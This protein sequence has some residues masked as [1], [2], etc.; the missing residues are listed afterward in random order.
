MAQLFP[1]F[2]SKLIFGTVG[3][4]I[5]TYSKRKNQVDTMI[6]SSENLSGVAWDP[7]NKQLYFC[8][9]QA[10][11]RARH[12]GSNVRTVFTTSK[13]KL[14]LKTAV[15]SAGLEIKYLQIKIADDPILALSF[16][17]ISGSLYGGTHTGQVFAC[18]STAAETLSCVTIMRGKHRVHG[19][20]VDPNHG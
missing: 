9:A 12:D 14:S 17:W 19:I 18:D 8:R 16:D 15:E 4:G 2:E 6:D 13:C 1:D 3:A 11:Y 20:A 5:K 10:I 7:V